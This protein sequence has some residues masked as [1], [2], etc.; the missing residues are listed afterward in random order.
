ML[1]ILVFLSIGKRDVFMWRLF[2]HLFRFFLPEVKIEEK[3]LLL[4]E[5]ALVVSN[6][7]GSIGPV[8]LLSFWP[9][10]LFPWIVS[11]MLTLRKA[12]LY[13]FEDF[14]KKEMH[15][16]GSIGKAVSLCLALIVV[17]FLRFL[18]CI[19]VYR[20]SRLITLTMERSLKVLLGGGKVVVFAEEASQPTKEGVA[21]LRHGFLKL[22]A[23]YWEKTGKPLRVIPV[24]ICPSS[25]RILVGES[26]SI[27]EEAL[28]LE[29]RKQKVLEIERIIRER[30]V[31]GRGNSPPL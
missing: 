2:Q 3:G 20:K 29:K 31:R 18:G 23:L 24:A 11:E 28:S 30:Y 5:P 4:G 27:G 19:P 26:F 25:R 15:L 21:P 6:H 9:E 1:E 17:P 14:V 8:W 13:L 16:K 12:P 22:A 10:R 7:V